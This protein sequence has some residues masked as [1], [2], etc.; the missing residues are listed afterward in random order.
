MAYLV[1]MRR[2]AHR[3]DPGSNLHFKA[4]EQVLGMLLLKFQSG[5]TPGS[6]SILGYSPEE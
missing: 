5:D 3:E 6:D 4:E 2:E 1:L